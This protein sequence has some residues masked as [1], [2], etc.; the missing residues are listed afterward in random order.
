MIAQTGK[1]RSAATPEVPTMEE[2]GLPGF[3]V[4]SGFGMFAPA[5]TPRPIIDRIHSA[6]VKALNDPKVKENL[7]GQGA[8]VVASTPEEYDRFNRTEIT[9]WI[10]VAGETGIVPE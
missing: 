3:V 9:K 10:K 2:S 7:A 5:G 4:S 8:D 1:Q 6:L